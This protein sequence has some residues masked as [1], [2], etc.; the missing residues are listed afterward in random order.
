MN[1]PTVKFNTSNNPEFFKVLRKRIDL[2]FKEK[3]ISKNANWNMKF[4]TVFMINLY[5]IPLILMLTGVV[6]GLWM[7]LLMWVIMGFGMGGIGLAVMHD[8]NHGSYSKNKTVNK[9][10]GLTR[11]RNSG[12]KFQESSLSE[13][14]DL[15]YPREK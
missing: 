7:V 8:A 5:L 2:H 12:V 10:L 14:S 15:P 6:S 1:Q 13:F 4:K 3:D 11:Q 9:S